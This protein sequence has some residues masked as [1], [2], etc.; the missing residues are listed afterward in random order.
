[1]F[2]LCIHV[3]RVDCQSFLLNR[4]AACYFITYWKFKERKEWSR[5]L[6]KVLNVYGNNIENSSRISKQQEMVLFYSVCFVAYHY[7]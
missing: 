7:L 6:Y 1:M 3:D 2:W 4:D 5:R